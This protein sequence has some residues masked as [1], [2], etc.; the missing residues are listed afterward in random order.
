MTPRRPHVI[1]S[2]HR[3]RIRDDAGLDDDLRGW[4]RD[5]YDRA[6]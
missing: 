1:F 3:V 6:G 2:S 4:L 5:A